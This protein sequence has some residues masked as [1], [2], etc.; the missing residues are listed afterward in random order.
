MVVRT[1]ESECAVFGVMLLD[2]EEIVKAFPIFTNRP[3]TG[4]FSTI[5]IGHNFAVF[6]VYIYICYS[7]QAALPS[8]SLRQLSRPSQ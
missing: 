8:Q 4:Y 5:P 2:A 7:L 1:H 6:D 3:D